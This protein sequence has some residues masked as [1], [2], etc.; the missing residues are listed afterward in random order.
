MDE[1]DISKRNPG[2]PGACPTRTTRHPPSRATGEGREAIDGPDE[3]QP[4]AATLWSEIA[5]TW[6]YSQRSGRRNVSIP[7][8]SL[9]TKIIIYFLFYEKILK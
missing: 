4:R 7:R 9:I 1:R 3:C 2:I 8:T 6:G 5:E